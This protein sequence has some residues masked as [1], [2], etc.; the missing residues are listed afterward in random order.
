MVLNL[1]IGL[2]V[3]TIVLYYVAGFVQVRHNSIAKAAMVTILGLVLGY[4]LA[5][6]VITFLFV[7]L[8]LVL[9]MLAVSLILRLLLI[10][11]VYNIGLSQT[12]FLWIFSAIA[13]SL[14]AVFLPFY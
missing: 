13:S 2:V 8:E 11:F 10:K 6:F 4:L 7:S 12:L 14:L 5:P 3:D 1:V 9:L